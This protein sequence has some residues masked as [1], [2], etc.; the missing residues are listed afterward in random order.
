MIL[1]LTLSSVALFLQHELSSRIDR[2]DNVFAGL[3]DR[4]PKPA[5]SA[6][7]AV[8]ILLLGTDR[9]SEEPAAERGTEA[10]SWL[11]GAQRSDAVMIVHIDS[12]RRGASV[13]SIP[14]DA[15]VDVPGHGPNKINAAF[16]FGGPSLAVR[17]IE[18]LTGIRIDHLAVIDWTGFEQ[19]T[20]SV[21]GVTLD[22]P[23]TTHDHYRDITWT[24]GRHVLDGKQALDYVG[25]RAG[26]PGGDLDRIHRQQY[27]LRTLLTET[28]HQ[29]LLK[30]PRQVYRILGTLTDNL[31]V[32]SGWSVAKM[33]RLL[34]SLRSLRSADIGYLTV[35]VSGTGT[36]G[37]QSVVYLDS[38]GND[39]LWR[40]A[41][42]D[43][44]SGWLAVNPASAV[45]TTVS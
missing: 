3:A 34:I 23:E 11:P 21:G 4:P 33:R 20:D 38:S 35:P 44:I 43:Q 12:D 25:Q 37:A 7:G 28:L 14:R 9:R 45:P 19:L 27:F 39:E 32:D 10:A 29:E 8:N 30:R 13:I 36:E 16:S 41:R 5:G 17:T 1:V 18:R 6:A 31:S 22:V 15:W 26:L 2:I 42:D 40:A 24:A